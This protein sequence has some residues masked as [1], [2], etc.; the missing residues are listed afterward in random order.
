DFHWP[1][2]TALPR[3]LSGRFQEEPLYVDLRWAKDSSDL[4]LRQSRFRVAV[5]NIGAPIRGVRKDELDGADVRQSRRNRLFVRTG[6]TVIAI[7]ALVAIWQAVI[8]TQ[9]R[10]EARRQTTIALSRALGALAQLKLTGK[11]PQLD[12]ALLIATHAVQLDESS[13]AQSA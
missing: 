1:A 11:E 13:G 6:V 12:V 3:E 9:Q 10:N 5:L 7:A 4:S 2:T 8:A